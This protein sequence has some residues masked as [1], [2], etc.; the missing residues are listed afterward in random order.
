[1]VGVEGDL[2]ASAAHLESSDVRYE[3]ESYDVGLKND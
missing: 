1:M 3:S 2:V